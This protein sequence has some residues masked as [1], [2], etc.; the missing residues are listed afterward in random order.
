MKPNVACGLKDVGTYGR[1]QNIAA[2]PSFRGHQDSALAELLRSREA[3]FYRT[4]VKTGF[5]DCVTLSCD[6]ITSVRVRCVLLLTPNSN[7]YDYAVLSFRVAAYGSRLRAH[8]VFRS[9]YVAS[10][11]GINRAW[12]YGSQWEMGMSRGGYRTRVLLLSRATCSTLRGV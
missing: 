2:I 5:L 8:A 1:L 7:S 4:D 9:K 6:T 10:H 11:E 3:C 12:L